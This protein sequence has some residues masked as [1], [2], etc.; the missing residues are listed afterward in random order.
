MHIW[1][2]GVLAFAHPGALAAGDLIVWLQLAPLTPSV[3][4]LAWSFQYFQTFAAQLLQG[5]DTNRILALQL[6]K[7]TES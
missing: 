2:R 5:T 6:G 3:S 1:C 4:V 7:E